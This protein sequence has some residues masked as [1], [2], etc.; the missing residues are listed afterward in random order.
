MATDMPYEEQKKVYKETMDTILEA[1]NPENFIHGM[2]QPTA[3]YC[4]VLDVN[5]REV[6]HQD[7]CCFGARIAGVLWGADMESLLYEVSADVIHG[8]MSTDDAVDT[9]IDKHL[10]QVEGNP[11]VKWD[12]IYHSYDLKRDIVLHV[13]YQDGIQ[14]ICD[15]LK[16][17]VPELEAFIYMCGGP[18]EPFNAYH[19]DYTIDP[20]AVAMK[21]ASYEV[22]PADEVARFMKLDPDLWKDRH[23]LREFARTWSLDRE[24]LFNQTTVISGD[25]DGYL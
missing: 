12:T 9:I 25:H 1:A 19:W 14:V 20:M 17:S 16:I 3:E 23:Y 10:P 13:D 5:N 18:F 6:V 11:P 7:S 24:T 2:H 21:M 22:F 8:R 4:V 15:A